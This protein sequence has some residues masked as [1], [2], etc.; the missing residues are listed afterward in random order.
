VT[1]TA[2]DLE[3]SDGPEEVPRLGGDLELAVEAVVDGL[4]YPAAEKMA[5]VPVSALRKYIVGL[6]GH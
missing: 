4:S 6:G 2:P 1:A 3:V 5:G